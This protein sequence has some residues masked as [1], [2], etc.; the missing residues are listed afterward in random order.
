MDFKTANIMKQ[1]SLS[2]IQNLSLSLVFSEDKISEDEFL[3]LKKTIGQLIGEIDSKMLVP[4]YQKYPD[5]D[6]LNK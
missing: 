6:D 2:A 1:L 4:L 3:L 5:L